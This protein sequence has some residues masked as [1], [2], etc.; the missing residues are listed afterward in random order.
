MMATAPLLLAALVLMAGGA[1]A[2]I[3]KENTTFELPCP[4]DGDLAYFLL[5]GQ[6]HVMPVFYESEDIAVYDNGSIIFQSI[7]V[8]DEGTHLCVRQHNTS[9]YAH[10]VSIRVRPLPPT[11]MWEYTYRSQ[12]VTGLIAALVIASIFALSCVIYKRQWKPSTHDKIVEPIVN[13]EGYDNPVMNTLE[14]GET[15]STHM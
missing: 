15:P 13:A 5:H 7:R 12:F 10:P 9:Y 11:N 14:E 8:E 3:A 1:L 2:N 4:G 6:G